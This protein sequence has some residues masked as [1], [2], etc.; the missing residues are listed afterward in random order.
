MRLLTLDLIA[1]GKFTDHRI[2]FPEGKGVYVIYGSNEAG[3]STCIRALRN[4]L[5]GIPANTQDD[6]FHEGKRLRVGGRLLGPDGKKRSVVRRKGLKSTL[7]DL[8]GQPIPEEEW[9]AF[10]G[11]IDRETFTRVFGLS[12]DELVSG[13]RVILEGKGGVGESLFTAG[14]GGADLKKVL[15]TLDSEAGDLFKPTGTL[16]RLNAEA[17]AFKELKTGIRDLSLLPKDWEELADT[18]SAFEERSRQLRDRIARLSAAEDRMKRLRDALPLMAELRVGEQKRAELGEVKILRKGFVLERRQAQLEMN[19]ALSEEKTAKKR[20][21]E[22]D[23]NL[24]TLVIPEVLLAQEKTIK[25][26]GEELGSALKAQ[27]DL[28]R[29]EGQVFEARQAAKA[30]LGEL[31]P[32]L[33]L[34]SA[35]VLR[36]TVKQVDRIRRLGEEHGRV[37]IRR[38]TA[39]DKVRE[40]ARKLTVAEKS[41]AEL[42]EVREPSELEQAAAFVRK[43]GELERSCLAARFEAQNFREDAEAALKGLPLWSGTLEDLESLPLPPEGTIETF[44]KLFVT[45]DDD[46]RRARAALAETEEKIAEVNGNLRILKLAG[47]PPTEEELLAA[48]GYRDQG[49]ALVRSAWL[50]GKRAEAAESAFSLSVPLEQAYE[51]SV[52]KADD[53]ADRMRREAEKV[54]HQAGLLAERTQQEE[55]AESLSEGIGQLEERR[56]GLEIDWESRWAPAGFSPLS[57]RE[58]RGWMSDW[59]DLARR[60]AEGRKL[61]GRVR[62][63]AE[64]IQESK[65][66]LWAGLAAVEEP[67]TARESSLE[68]ILLRA[69][70]LVQAAKDLRVK[71]DQLARASEEARSGKGQAGE[72]EKK[73]AETFARWEKDWAEAVKGLCVDL[74]VSAAAVFLDKCQALMSKLEEAEKNQ[75]RINNMKRDIQAFEGRV[76]D[77]VARYALDLIGGRV[78]QTVRDLSDRVSK[79]KADA[80]S[81]ANLSAERASRLKDLDSARETIRAKSELLDSLR[82]EAG[83][84]EDGEFPEAETRSEDACSLD[85]RITEL[86]KQILVLAAGRKVEVF[87]GEV[88]GEDPER[89]LQELAKVSTDLEEAQEEFG[90]VR[91]DLGAAGGRLQAMDG[92]A[93]AA[94]AAQEA[95]ERLGSLRE[96]AQRYLRVRLAAKI[97]R[98]EVEK[99]RE[100]S[101]GPVLKR[102]GELFTPLTQKYFIGLEPD[103][104]A[105]DE[106]ILVGIRENGKKVTLA[107]MSDGTQDQIY[108]ALRLAS[109]EHFIAGGTALPLLVDDALVNFDDHRARAALELFG[110]LANTTQVIFFT[111]HQHM[112]ELAREAIDEEILQVQ[113]LLERA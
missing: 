3:K 24:D 77:F 12:R 78:D 16:P 25:E 80:A 38:Q 28:P 61:D 8:D 70:E 109:L 99:Y 56:G 34:E 73:Q 41:L 79:A 23:G 63:W 39:A 76:K 87:T 1:Y 35:G 5:Y 31:R 27:K 111:H 51:T 20:I 90:R 72:E 7:A 57:P 18:V 46:L 6:F 68:A 74:P 81:R 2:D 15:D 110:D 92:R 52:L 86:K 26:L 67:V 85:D 54:A 107:G 60:A 58:M 45:L 64:E 88:E 17:K 97:L 95:Q 102:A 13:G 104:S 30:I 29:V 36:L 37:T 49:W 50:E 43:K 40:Y 66:A 10:L 62:K 83:C 47:E 21:E 103:Y 59:K 113:E 82:R 105:G 4:L 55:G 91:L 33:D 101:Q 11:G 14:L 9:K 75:T 53:L 71:R 69:E 96:N 19:Q 106:P 32:D 94:R 100:K 65:K 22:I 108:L 84:R 93:D 44:E 89:V 42:P 112:V 98:S 48:R